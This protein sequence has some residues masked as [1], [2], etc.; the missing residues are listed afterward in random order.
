MSI[1][2][3]KELARRDVRVSDAIQEIGEGWVGEE[4]LAIAVYCSLK[5]SDNFSSGVTAAVNHSGDSDSTGAIT[6]AILGT[7]L[8]YEAIPEEWIDRLENSQEIEDISCEMYR[9]FKE[10]PSEW[11]HEKD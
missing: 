2:L 5:F 11:L 8:G 9:I 1:H 3:A 10:Q 4:A 6:G 7:L